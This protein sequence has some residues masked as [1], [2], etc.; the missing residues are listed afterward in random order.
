MV[1][2]NAL[3][4]VAPVAKALL[5]TEFVGA[6]LSRLPGDS[7]VGASDGTAGKGSREGGEGGDDEGNA[8]CRVFP[9]IDLDDEHPLPG[10]VLNVKIRLDI[11]RGATTAGIAEIPSN[12]RNRSPDRCASARRHGISLSSVCPEER[13]GLPRFASRSNGH[14]SP[15]VTQYPAMSIIVPD[16]RITNVCFFFGD[17]ALIVAFQYLERLCG[18]MEYA[19]TRRGDIT[20]VSLEILVPSLDHLD[21][22][23]DRRPIAQDGRRYRNVTPFNRTELLL[24]SRAALPSPSARDIHTRTAIASDVG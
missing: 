17:L 24:I 8:R 5:T 9:H 7:P 4:N 20:L 14:R 13:G 6:A 19:C 16:H 22:A 15:W 23:I 18:D 10:V 11:S 3:Q 12:Y 2:R 21:K 1:V